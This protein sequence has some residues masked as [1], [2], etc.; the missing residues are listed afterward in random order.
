MRRTFGTITLAALTASLAGAPTVRAQSFGAAQGDARPEEPLDLASLERQAAETSALLER[1]SEEGRRLEEEEQGLGP[2]REAL[3]RR[4]RSE[5]RV[6]YHLAQSQ[7][8]AVQGGPETALEHAART[9][10]VRRALHATLREIDQATRR[11]ATLRVDRARTAA[12][13]AEARARHDALEARRA[14]TALLAELRMPAAVAEQGLGVVPLASGM[15]ATPASDAITV[16]GGSVTATNAHEASFGEA[17]GR[18]LFPVGG[19][20]EVRH[21]R[22]EGAEGPGVEIIAPLGTP[23]RAVFPGRVAFADRYGT[24]GRIVI[25]DHGEHYYTVSANLGTLNVRVGQE[26]QTGAVLGT[27]GDDGRGPMLYFEVR[28]GSETVDPGPWLGL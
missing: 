16:Y 22:R 11:A 1:L 25:L 10:R 5:I 8:L 2:R 21:A 13:L 20:A 12:A 9:E 17:A 28:H 4:A 18:L 26:V 19:R 23:V 6:L 3:V 14:R 27:V 24:Y 7:A 15:R